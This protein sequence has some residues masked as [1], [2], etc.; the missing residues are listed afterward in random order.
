[1]RRLPCVHVRAAADDR[2]GG[3]DRPPSR[4][5]RGAHPFRQ[6]LLPEPH[7]AKGI[8]GSHGLSSLL[9]LRLDAGDRHR[10]DSR[11]RRVGV[12]R[13]VAHLRGDHWCVGTPNDAD[14]PIRGENM[15]QFMVRTIPGNYAELYRME[16]DA[17]RK[18][19]R[20]VWSWQGRF[21]RA[22]AAYVVFLVAMIA[23]G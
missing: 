20:S 1:H 4:R 17:A 7:A 6:V 16:S 22:V 19:G 13:S 10:R 23:I 11:R 21:T 2:L 18:W 8:G 14:T 12:A 3:E 15:Y 5:R 9:S